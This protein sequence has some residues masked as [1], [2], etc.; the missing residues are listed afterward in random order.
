MEYVVLCCV[1]TQA[2]SSEAIKHRHNITYRLV[3]HF[4]TTHKYHH[5]Y[6]CQ[7]PSF[8]ELQS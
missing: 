6:T 8:L 3:A 7:F 5:Y 1:Y 2:Q 4:I